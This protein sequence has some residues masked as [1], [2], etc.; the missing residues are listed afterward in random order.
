M[1]FPLFFSFFIFFFSPFVLSPR[2][3]LS[4]VS[5]PAPI[6]C[7]VA[8]QKK[9]CEQIHFW[10][11]HNFD[12]HFKSFWK[13]VDCQSANEAE[14]IWVASEWTPWVRTNVDLSII[15]V[16]VYTCSLELCV[17]FLFHLVAF[18]VC[19]YSLSCLLAQLW[20]STIRLICEKVHTFKRSASFFIILFLTLVDDVDDVDVVLW[21]CTVEIKPT[22]TTKKEKRAETREWSWCW[23]F[24]V[25][26]RIDLFIFFSQTLYDLFVFKHIAHFYTTNFIA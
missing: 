7:I 1:Q 23:L 20:R 13:F 18:V 22:M 6:S 12:W 5:N 21:M 25:C 15:L 3:S 9:T 10:R 2:L 26:G 14:C 4:R 8:D 16:G 19:C 24:G 17:W 11:N